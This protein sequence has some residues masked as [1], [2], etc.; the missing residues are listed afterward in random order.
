MEN[1]VKV[2]V[3]QPPAYLP[4][5]LH[6]QYTKA[7]NDAF[8]QA[9]E[10]SPGDLPT[11]RQAAMREANRVLKVPELTS[12]EDAIALPDWKVIKR[13]VIGADLK[14][15][16]IDGKKYAFPVPPPVDEDAPK[17]EKTKPADARGG[18]EQTPGA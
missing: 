10:D 4:V 18:G 11:Q 13:E 9:Q 3:P 12:Y 8:K 14:V 5:G 1:E 6:K 15:V 7:F 2:D 17:G 16:T